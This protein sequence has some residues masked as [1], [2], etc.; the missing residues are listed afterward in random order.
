MPKVGMRPLRRRQ[1]IDAT[2]RTIES[3]GLAETTIARISQAAGLSSGIIGHYFGGKNALLAAT[4]RTLLTELRRSTT[5]RLREA[6]TAVERIEAILGANIGPEQFTPRVVSVWLAFYA[7]VPYEPELA[8]LHRVYVRRLRSN[9]RHAFKALLPA[10]SA[11][12]AAEGMGALIDGIW[13]RAALAREAPD[14]ERAHALADGY[15]RMTLG[16]H[17]RPR[18]SFAAAAE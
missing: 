1:L 18:P 12:E 17:T 7:Q 5:T 2:I 13:V 3:H 8:R 15:L 6:S 9:L 4:M 16:H 11:A 14:I 10:A